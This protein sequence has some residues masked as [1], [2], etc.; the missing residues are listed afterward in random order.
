MATILRRSNTQN[1]KTPASRGNAIV[2][3]PHVNDSQMPS[4]AFD[5]IKNTIDVGNN[6]S[7]QGSM[8]ALSLSSGRSSSTF[9]KTQSASSSIRRNSSMTFSDY[10][11]LDM[12][13]QESSY[14]ES[15]LFQTAFKEDVDNCW[16]HFVDVAAAD[17]ELSRHSRFQDSSYSLRRDNDGNYRQM[18]YS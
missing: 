7:I 14:P 5:D 2:Y 11:N 10:Q 3:H 13:M 15:L 8:E 18:H 17:E 4:L 16:G 1:Y 12:S 6:N 9:Q